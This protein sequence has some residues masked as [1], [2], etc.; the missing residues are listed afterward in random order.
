VRIAVAASLLA[1]VGLLAWRLT[2]DPAPPAKTDTAPVVAAVTPPPPPPAPSVEETVGTREA[3]PEPT[4]EPALRPDT[5]EGLHALI[6]EIAEASV[7][8]PE[9]AAALCRGLALPDPAAWFE[10]TF[11]G[12][13]GA[14]LAAEHEPVTK[15]FGTLP[16]LFQRLRE[17]GQTEILVEV[18]QDPRD[19]LA[20]G[21]QGVAM[22]AM[23]RPVPLYSVRMLQPGQSTGLSLWSF[24]YEAGAFRFAGEMR[25]VD[26]EERSAHAATLGELRRRDAEHLLETGEFPDDD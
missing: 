15:R 14:R 1:L 5:V 21:Y 7:A 18:H 11:G 9:Q 4:S 24:V 25:A 10:R 23:K 19:P 8:E 6:R 2:G 20:T 3:E 17:D 26:P 16:R 12:V 22:S 13:V